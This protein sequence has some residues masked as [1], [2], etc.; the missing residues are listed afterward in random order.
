MAR[1]TTEQAVSAIRAI[2]TAIT[3]EAIKGILMNCDKWTMVSVYE[4]MEKTSWGKGISHVRKADLMHKVAWLLREGIERKEFLAMTVQEKYTALT[5]R[6]YD[7]ALRIVIYC[8]ERDSDEIGLMLGVKFTRQHSPLHRWDM[9]LTAIKKFEAGEIPAVEVAPT[10]DEISKTAEK[11]FASE[12]TGDE[13]EAVMNKAEDK[14]LREFAQQREIPIDDNEDHAGL[15]KIVMEDL[16]CEKLGVYDE[17]P[18]DG[19]TFIEPEQP[20]PVIKAVKEATTVEAIRD[21]L[22]TCTVKDM[23]KVCAEVTGVENGV[24]MCGQIP[25]GHAAKKIADFI[26][27]HREE[28]K[29]ELTKGIQS[30]LETIRAAK[31]E[32]YKAQDLDGLT[33]LRDEVREL[34]TLLEHAQQAVEDDLYEPVFQEMKKKGLI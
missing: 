30:A 8:T 20:A 23:F 22:M 26:M 2:N 3:V 32:L 34:A 7:Y 15:V 11:Y 4:E 16:V 29:N 25:R 28:K 24:R 5:T 1:M 6:G 21:V 10:V 13:V 31:D 9:L 27:K 17:E 12:M 33:E 19:E 14:T 18:T